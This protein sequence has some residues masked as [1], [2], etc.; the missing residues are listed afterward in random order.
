MFSIYSNE[1]N[2]AISFAV[3]CVNDNNSRGLLKVG[4]NYRAYST[5]IYTQDG[6]VLVKLEVSGMIVPFRADRFIVTGNKH[7]VD[8]QEIY[9]NDGN[10]PLDSF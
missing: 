4:S 5:D 1:T 7:D 6:M 8:M 3:K 10:H 2:N 9:N